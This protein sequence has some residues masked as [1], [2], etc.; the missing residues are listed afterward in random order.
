MGSNLNFNYLDLNRRLPTSP[1]CLPIDGLIGKPRINI[2]AKKY[3]ISPICHIN[4]CRNN[5][6]CPAQKFVCSSII[7]VYTLL[8]VV[9]NITSKCFCTYTGLTVDLQ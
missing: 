6:L 4:M 3:F 2:P 7:V 9:A 8:K 5:L 1:N